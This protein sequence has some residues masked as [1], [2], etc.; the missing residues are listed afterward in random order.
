MTDWFA[1]PEVRHRCHLVLAYAQRH[2]IQVYPSNPHGRVAFDGVRVGLLGEQAVQWCKQVGWLM[3]GYVAPD[4]AW[5]LP[6][7]A[8]KDQL[9][10]WNA[11]VFGAPAPTT[12]QAAP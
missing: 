3:V 11:E 1:D 9:R 8:G 5:M 12:Q 4:R 2:R 10:D 6:T 7:T